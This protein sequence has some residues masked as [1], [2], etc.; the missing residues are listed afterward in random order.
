MLFGFLRGGVSPITLADR[1]RNQGAWDTAARHYLRALRRKPKNPPIWVQYGHVLK[2]QGKLDEAEQA[3]RRAIAIDSTT[4]DFYL[5]L[6]HLLKLQG[7]PA[8]T[9]IAYIHAFVLD[10]S[11]PDA[12]AELRDVGWSADRLSLLVE[13][14]DSERGDRRSEQTVSPNGYDDATDL[15]AHGLADQ[16]PAGAEAEPIAAVWDSPAS[17]VTDSSLALPLPNG[18]DDRGSAGAVVEF[19]AVLHVDPEQTDTKEF[20]N[21]A[22]AF[23]SDSF[24]MLRDRVIS[25]RVRRVPQQELRIEVRGDGGVLGEATVDQGTGEFL[26]WLPWQ[27]AD[28]RPHQIEVMVSG[29]GERLIGQNF[30]R[31]LIFQAAIAVALDEF[32]GGALTGWAYD[33]RHPGDSLVFELLDGDTVVSQYETSGLRTD[34]DRALGI[35]GK[36]GFTSWLPTGLF[37]GRSHDLKLRF[38]TEMVALRG[39]SKMPRTFPALQWAA[40]EHRFSGR[41][42][43][44][45]PTM[46]SGWAI[47]KMAPESPVSVS[48]IV[49]GEH[50]STIK[51][52]RYNPR[53][54]IV[55]NG[56]QG[57]LFRLPA[58]LMNGRR[59]A[60][61]VRLT[62]MQG[63]LPS[64]SDMSRTEHAVDFPL[65]SLASVRPSQWKPLRYHHKRPD[66]LLPAPP[67]A[68]RS[69]G[70][71]PKQGN[72]AAPEVSLIV[73]NRNGAPL[74]RQFLDSCEAAQISVSYEILLIDHASNDDSIAVAE[75]F[76]NRLPIKVIPR[77]ANFSF[78]ASNNFGARQASGRYLGFV[79]NDLILTEDCITPLR[80]R[81]AADDDVGMVGVKLYEPLP[82]DRSGWVHLPHHVGIQFVPVVG[83]SWLRAAAA[84][85]PEE[86]PDHGGETVS[87]VYDV[88]AVTAALSMCRKADFD[89]VEGF[90][91]NYFYG[92]E[93]VDLCMNL[94]ERLGRRIICDT[95]IA[96]IHH[97]SATRE[98]RTSTGGRSQP[99]ADLGEILTRNRHEFIRRHARRLKKDIL[100]SLIDGETYWRRSPLRVT[101]V[102]SE[103]TITTSAGDFFT[104]LEL[105]EAMH[106]EFGWEVMFCE[107]LQYDVIGSDVL[108]VMRH[109]YELNKIVNPNPGIV[110]VAWIRNRVDEWL[111][112]PNFSA[113][114]LIFCSSEKARA[115]VREGAGRD[116]ILLPIA[117]NPERFRPEARCPEF[118]SEIAFTGHYWSRRIEIARGLDPQATRDGVDL[119]NPAELPYDF[120][121]YG[122]NWDNSPRWSSYCRGPLPYQDMPKVYASAKIVLDDSHPVTR[123]W[124]SLNSRVF[125]AAAAGSLVLTNCAGGAREV[126]GDLLPSYTT[127][128][129][130]RE[131]ISFYL[132][133]PAERE[134]RAEALSRSVR[135]QHSY[136]VRAQTFRAGLRQFVDR[137][138]RFG[139]KIGVPADTQRETWGDWHFALGIKRALEARGHFARI[140]LLPDWE[141]PI[142]F[143]DDVALVLRGLSQFTPSPAMVNIA[144][145]I[146]HP[147]DVA[148]TELKQYDHV[149]VA[150]ESYSRHLEPTLGEKVS[151]LLQCTDERLFFPD[152]DPELAVPEVIF[153]GNSRKQRRPVVADA[154]AAGVDFGVFGADW[155]GMVPSDTWRSPHI[156]NDR[157]RHYYS[158]AAV[159]LNDHW[160]DMAQ[161]GFV[162]NRIFDA[163]ACG[164]TIVSDGVNG[165]NELFD[166]LVTVY[167]GADDLGA[168]VRAAVEDPEERRARGA[169][170]AHL[171]AHRHTFAHRVDTIIATASRY[172]ESI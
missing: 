165:L 79:N 136:K 91:E 99:A 100:T 150:S 133:H 62:G 60:V 115:A 39:F 28:N 106:D 132:E 167:R 2:E 68:A 117:S 73:L 22:A 45:S 105:G 119:L 126:F 24:W 97:R 94:R 131:L 36:H 5:Q 4:A 66:N 47:D 163:G 17:P 108:I 92:M 50:I 145:L 30:P 84:H 158:G 148:A 9:E 96:A 3:Y 172:L 72:P 141:L 85:F 77:N 61:A 88:P 154:L 56:F 121:I 157:L 71:D 58:S 63:L 138:L 118:A 161:Q 41:V 162:S 48:L 159:V 25:G 113:Y 76:G 35:T 152:V 135:E 13:S 102:V 149:F 54:Q 46:V 57:F 10:P 20:S 37:D 23:I 55:G 170:L 8:E 166:D 153:V 125:D 111:E 127:P 124:N 6:G 32:H 120:A 107:Y 123:I 64:S 168:K 104:A 98:D 122:R 156:P 74:L 49:D 42:E 139:I 169:R 112:A 52:R 27:L 103:A 144:W 18:H 134:K 89:A 109:D 26:F 40:I 130:L 101:F 69:D 21:G 146:S 87:G 155:E 70:T 82:D 53:F 31:P 15:T 7:K 12:R 83:V 59:R 16:I 137:T 143:G 38:G 164:A 160:P 116:S 90:N 78:S 147:E 171:I 93:D 14:R 128:E 11:L 142:T 67:A 80:D 33:V 110:T 95:G 51:A 1:A 75:S 43:N 129:E 34:V 29:S 140:D 151:P 19:D 114:A 86:I 65:H 81:L 44:V